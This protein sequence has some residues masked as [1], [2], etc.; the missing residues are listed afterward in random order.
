MITLRH[1]R[2]ELELTHTFRLARGASDVRQT[3]VLELE[4]EGLTGLGEAAPIDRYDQDC[5]SA[6]RAAE[7]MAQRLTSPLA[8]DSAAS[9]VAVPGEVAAEAAMD[10]AVCDLAAKK[11]GVPLYELMGID[12][13]QAPVTSFT[14]GMDTPEVVEAKVREAGEYEVLKIKMG[15]DEDRQILEAVRGVTDRPLRVD[16]N[17]GWTLEGAQ[18]RLEWLES[19]GVELVE[20]PLP[21]GQLEEM[22]E[23]RRLSPL[24]LF[25]DESVYR[26]ADI[27]RLAGAFDGINIKLMKCGGLG[28]ARRMIA[29]ARAH[30]MQVMLGCMVESSLAITAAAH[31]S[32]LV[33]FADLDGNLLIDNDP[34]VGVTVK[35]GRLVLPGG[36]G[37][38]VRPRADPP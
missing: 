37:L 25:A 16:A 38:G 20:Q 1:Y 15:S 30:G 28:E 35:G 29:V 4:E 6:A 11:L 17:E 18:S 8:Y 7:A 5:A 26:A 21:A 9:S 13:R 27:P 36:P 12:P 22:R 34:F 3:L 32:P 2:Q 14:I 19:M 24:P 33:D 31:L 23:L 10:M